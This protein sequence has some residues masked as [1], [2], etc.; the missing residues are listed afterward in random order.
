MMATVTDREQR[1]RNIIEEWADTA[2]E[3]RALARWLIARADE[4]D[5]LNDQPRPRHITYG[6]EYR[7]CGKPG[8]KCA[9]GELHGPY[10]VA[11]W[12]E[13][14]KTKRKHI[15]KVWRDLAGELSPG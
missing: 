8:C 2:D 14:G 10:W 7:R 5:A 9:S 12:T 6:Q 4:I 3:L 11:T 1:M 13:G 15:G